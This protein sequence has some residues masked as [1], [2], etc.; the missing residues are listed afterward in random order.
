VVYS[1]KESNVVQPANYSINV[2]SPLQAFGQAAQFGAGLAEMDAR[3]QAQQQ[4]AV[5]QQALNTEFQRVSTIQNPQA[6]DFMGLS[7]LLPP[8]QMES[9]R[10][11]YEQGSQEQKDNQLL[12][13]GKVLSAFTSGQNQIGIDLLENRA[14]AEENS[15]RK[16]QGQAFRSYAELA[17][18]NPGAAKATIGMLLATLPGGDKII[19]A[20]TKAQLAPSQISKSQADAATAQLEAADA[21]T[22]LNLGNIK[23]RAEINNINSTIKNRTD[24]YNLDK[25]KLTGDVQAKLMELN[26]K[27]G[28]L[29]P[30]A[31]KIINDSVVSSIGLE[32]AAGLTLDLATKLEQAAGRAGITAK[33]SESLK[34]IS[35]NQDALTQLRNEYTRIRNSSAIKSLPPGVATDKDIELALKGIPPETA[36]AATQ[37]SFLRGMAKMQQYEA[38]TESAKSEWV[39]STGNLGRSKSDIEIGG[40]R[41][42]KGTT[43]PEFARQFMD[44]RAQDLAATQSNTAVSGRSYMKYANPTGQ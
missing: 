29:E 3:R 34:S 24:Q 33:F 16:E 22:R 8:A 11:T 12:F 2:Q 1:V 32:Q 26:Q 44:R 5:R 39:N 10:K 19:E 9:V 36:N 37:A 41:V 13:S 18:I 25:D 35:G 38:A 20:T 17:R 23:T 4:E 7:F 6:K 21:P 15:G 14:T 28:T 31:V 43:F 30:S 42:P 27:Q 40:I